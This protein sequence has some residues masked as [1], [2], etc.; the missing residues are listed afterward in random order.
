MTLPNCT[1]CGEPVNPVVAGVFRRVEGWVETRKGG[2]AHGVTFKKELGDYAH[3][4]C[5]DLER[6]GVGSEQTS[7]FSSILGEE[8]I[9]VGFK[10]DTSML[11]GM[12]CRIVVGQRPYK[13]KDGTMQIWNFVSD[14][15]NARQAKTAQEIF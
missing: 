1:F 14:V 8:D 4:V 15:I 3:K 9:P 5:I 11:V 13:A 7:L 6:K 2:G 12:P 10:F